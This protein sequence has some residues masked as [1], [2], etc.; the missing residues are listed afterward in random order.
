MPFLKQRC[1]FYFF[2]IFFCVFILSKNNAAAETISLP[3]HAE[4]ETDVNIQT[5]TG[6][7]LLLVFPSEYGPQQAD[8]TLL[9]VLPQYGIEVWLSNLLETYFLPHSASNLEKIPAKDI[10]HLIQAIHKRSKKNIIILTSGRGAIPVL[11]ALA[12]WPDSDAPPYLSGLILMHPKLFVKTPEPGLQ[13]ELMPSVTKTNQLIY[14]IQPNLSPFWWNK[15]ISL[16]GLQQSGSD[17]FVQVLRNIRNRFYFREDANA[18]EQQ[19]SKKYPNLIYNAIDQIIR[20]PKK[21]RT[22]AS[23]YTASQLVTSVKKQLTLSAY[24]GK[25][26]PPPL[27]LKT[28]NGNTYDLNDDKNKVVLVNFWASWCPPCVHEM[29]SMQR[30]ENHFNKKPQTKNKFKI[31][32]VNMAE[33]KKTLADFLNTKVSVKFDILLDSDGS[34]LKQWKIF[35]FPTSFI[36]GKQGNI[37]Y[38]IYGAIDWFD[39][40]IIQ[41]IQQLIDE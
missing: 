20:H 26:V 29:P 32:A 2:W 17:V 5:A 36:I 37:R 8:T 19:L 10:Q 38:A 21:Q 23:G 24:K 13:A 3:L 14:L 7:T 35:A 11:R 22:I 30:L 4:L 1:P 40:D 18:I 6:N 28:L 12:S 9:Q 34:A 16:Q 27:K 39:R 31:L 15:N 41:K 25:P 33:D